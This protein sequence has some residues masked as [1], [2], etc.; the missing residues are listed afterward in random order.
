[1]LAGE[2]PVAMS[3]RREGGCLERANVAR[4]TPTCRLQ[5]PGWADQNGATDGATLRG[6]RFMCSAKSGLPADSLLMIEHV[7]GSPAVAGSS[8]NSP[9]ALICLGLFILRH[10]GSRRSRCRLAGALCRVRSAFL[11]EL[12]SEAA[13]GRH[14]PAANA[15]PNAVRERKARTPRA[16]T[17]SGPASESRPATA[18]NPAGST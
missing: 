2:S 7:M 3:R 1:M 6:Y 4:Q 14:V 5:V 17:R 9:S 10:T 8:R 11:S 18:R 13:G 12:G 15:A 16:G